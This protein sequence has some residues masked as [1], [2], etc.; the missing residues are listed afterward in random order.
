MRFHQNGSYNIDYMNLFSFLIKT[1]LITTISISAVV[2]LSCNSKENTKT[3]P[4]EKEIRII[5]P[6]N[7]EIPYELGMDYT[8]TFSRLDSDLGF[9]TIR[10]DKDDDGNFVFYS[11][12]D[13]ND[14]EF[15]EVMKGECFLTLD[16][17]QRMIKYE[18]TME[19]VSSDEN[20][21]SGKYEIKISFGDDVD[22][23]VKL[24]PEMDEPQ[25]YSL[26]I[27]NDAF[28]FDY[29]FIGHMALIASQPFLKS[30]R[31]E[32]LK[33]FTLYQENIFTLTMT[34]KIKHELKFGPE[35][36]IAYEVDMKVADVTFGHYYITSNG[37]ILQAQEEGGRM[38]INLVPPD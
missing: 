5:K 6:G 28:L 18:R 32:T 29:K 13:T 17:D 12:I 23:V 8:Y 10:L 1:V 35:N 20:L 3:R 2:A 19:I 14:L 21:P 15:N 27:P 4:P 36:V 7:R 22:K 31:T 37:I 38:L 25:E 26:D 9:A 33:V 16:A 30:G 34:P 11:F 24:T